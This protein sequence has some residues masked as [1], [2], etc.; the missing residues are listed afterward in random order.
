[1]S[2]PAFAYRGQRSDEDEQAF[3]ERLAAELE[4]EFSRVGPGNVAAFVAETVVGATAGCV[5]A[6]RNLLRLLELE[7]IDRE[8]RLVERKIRQARFGAEQSSGL[9]PA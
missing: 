5:P 7:V 8:R 1:M 3:G 9:R 4:A 2:P 6:P